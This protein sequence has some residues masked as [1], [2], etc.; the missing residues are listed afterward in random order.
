VEIASYHRNR[1][2]VNTLTMPQNYSVLITKEILELFHINAVM[3]SSYRNLT[4][5]IELFACGGFVL[6]GRL[7]PIN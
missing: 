5:A 3:L 4:V 1:V 2:K 7:N 6:D